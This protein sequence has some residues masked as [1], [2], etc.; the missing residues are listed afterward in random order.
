LLDVPGGN[1]IYAAVGAAVWKPDQPVGL[2]ARVGEDYPREWLD[3][4]ASHDFDL[5]GVRV[6]PE[7]I[8]LRSFYI[9]TDTNTRQA[10]DP[11]AH[12]SR[13]GQ[14]FPRSLLGYRPPASGMDSRTRLTP[15]SLRQGDIPP[16]YLD[17]TAAHLCPLDYLTHSLLPA[18]LRQSGFTTVTLDPSAGY[19]NPIFWDDLPA[20]IT[21][22]TAFLPSEEEVRS[23]FHGRSADLREMAEALAVYGSEFILIKRGSRGQLLYDAVAHTHWEVPSYPIHVVDLTGAGDAFCGGFMVG[24]R[25][26]YDPLQAALYGNISASM[27]VEG[28]GAFYALDALPGLAQARLDALRETVRRV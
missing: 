28:S 1:L 26:T 25:R 21:G 9:Y 16:D 18:V 14:A 19:M 13:L 11:V 15:T 17:A 7:A 10:D 3:T 5:R 6:L 12:F 2:V 27:T 22:L 8:D 4:L 24:Y 23:L 20:L